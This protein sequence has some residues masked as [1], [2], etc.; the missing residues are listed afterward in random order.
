MISYIIAIPDRSRVWFA[1]S[2]QKQHMLEKQHMLAQ[3]MGN[4]VDV[5]PAAGPWVRERPV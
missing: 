5:Q 3:T 2:L 4:D 1:S